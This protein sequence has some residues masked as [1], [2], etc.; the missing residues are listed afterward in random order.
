MQ[1]GIAMK[2]LRPLPVNIMSLFSMTKLG[3]TSPGC[4]HDFWFSFIQCKRDTLHYEMQLMNTHAVERETL[5]KA[6]L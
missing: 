6:S 2:L 5:F 4:A 1:F 3:L